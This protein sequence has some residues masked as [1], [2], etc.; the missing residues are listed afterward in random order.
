MTGKSI[1]IGLAV[2]MVSMIVL[3]GCSTEEADGQN[4]MTTSKPIILKAQMQTTRTINDLQNTDL[5]TAVTVGVFSLSDENTLLTNGDNAAYTTD[6]NG[7]LTATGSAMN[8]PASGS[9]SIYAYAPW[10]SAWSYDAEKT[11]TVAADQSSDEGYLASDLLYASQTATS[12]TS[13]VNLGFSHKLARL[14]LTV[15]ADASTTLT[16]ATVKIVGTKPSTVLTLAD[17]TISEATGTA[18]DITIGSGINITAGQSQTLYAVVVPQTIAANAT[19]IEVTAG[20]K[21]W[22]YHFTDAK[23]LAGGKSHSLTVSVSISKVTST[24][25]GEASE[26]AN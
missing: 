21:M 17:C 22:K 11:F 16:D 20:S 24:I 26:P 23:T 3:T 25:S 18:Q 10:Q 12:Q 13:A 4:V 2:I 9:V 1:F 6:G 5:S 8:W 7:N 14:A 19:L 15:T